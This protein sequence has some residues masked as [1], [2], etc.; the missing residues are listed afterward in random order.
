MPAAAVDASAPG[1]LRSSTH[2]ESPAC[3]RRSAAV[4]PMMPPPTMMTSGALRLRAP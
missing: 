1:T 2:T 3:A 4:H